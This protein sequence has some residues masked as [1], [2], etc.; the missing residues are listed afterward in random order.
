VAAELFDH[1][2][3]TGFEGEDERV[4]CSP[5]NGTPFDV[6]RYTATFRLA[7]DMAGIVGRVRPFHDMRHSSVTNGAAAGESQAGLQKRAGHSSS[8][9]RRSTSTGR[10]VSFPVG[11]AK[12][13]ARMWGDDAGTNFRYKLA[14][15]EAAKTEV[16]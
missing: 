3:R 14:A 1:R 10:G 5:T 4:F 13:A 16:H 12:R 6:A 11:T 9:R 2:A 15:D 7:L 8:R